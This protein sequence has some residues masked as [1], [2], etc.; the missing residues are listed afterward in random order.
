MTLR[1]HVSLLALVSLFSINSSMAEPGLKKK[2]PSGESL[3]TTR[4]SKIDGVVEIMD[5]DSARYLDTKSTSRLPVPSQKSLDQAL[6]EI[7]RIKIINSGT[8]QGKALEGSVILDTSDS[9]VIDELRVQ[10][11][12]K[13]DPK[14]FGHDMC[15]GGPCIEAYSKNSLKFCL[16]VQHGHAIRW[17]NWSADAKLLKPKEFISWLASKGATGPKQ[18]MERQIEQ[19]KFDSV[20]SQQARLDQFIKSMPASMKNFFGT[21]R[22]GLG[23]RGSMSFML[24]DMSPQYKAIPAAQ[25]MDAARTAIASQFEKTQ[26]QIKALLEWSAAIEYPN[27]GAYRIFPTEVLLEYDPG[28]ILAVVKAGAKGSSTW[29]GASRLYSYMGFRDKFLDGYPDLDVPLK[30]R[31]LEELNATG[32]NQADVH[33]FQKTISEW[34]YPTRREAILRARKTRGKE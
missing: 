9:R 21:I 32:K 17:V 3:W 33:E 8:V 6:G 18:E 34:M 14:S 1:L 7:T 12:I 27:A 24:E 13:E 30:Q 25:R 5:V 23:E 2:N 26:E 11:K 10:L 20:E 31:I 19:A 28:E 29:V 16:G 15:L 22:L 4:P